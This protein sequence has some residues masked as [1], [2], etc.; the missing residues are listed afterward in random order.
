MI[1]KDSR[2]HGDITATG[3]LI[4]GAGVRLGNRDR[5]VKIRCDGEI[6]IA[7]DVE[8]YGVVSA[9]KGRVV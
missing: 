9:L 5:E 8:I 4:I 6:E 7:E 1:G 3:R 2:I